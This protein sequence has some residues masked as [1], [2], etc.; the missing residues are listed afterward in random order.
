M[1]FVICRPFRFC[2]THANTFYGHCRCFTCPLSPSGTPD[3]CPGPVDS[4]EASDL[5]T[6]TANPLQFTFVTW[7]VRG[8]GDPRKQRHI[9]SYL[10]RHNVHCAMLQE[11]HLPPATRPTFANR[12]ATIREFSS[13]SSYA[14]GT[15]ILFNRRIPYTALGTYSDPQGRY[16]ILW[17]RLLAN[18]I[19]LVACYGPNT[20]DPE[21]FRVLWGKIAD[22]GSTHVLW[23]GDLNVTLDPQL[24]R[25][26]PQPHHYS[27]ARRELIDILAENDLVDAW[28]HTYP[29]GQ[30]GTCYS[31][32][33]SS[34]SR[35]DYWLMDKASASWLVRI[36]HL[37]RT[38]SDHSPVLLT[39]EPPATLPPFMHWRLNPTHLLDEAFKA[40]L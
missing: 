9:L 16:C 22:I 33:H 35:L 30:E 10:T 15:V 39:L 31:S 38:Y 17:G 2:I 13:Y 28:R 18:T 25:S 26:N 1:A 20:D 27:Q 12:W 11:T 3:I 34:W 29:T 21:F 19:T 4:D 5:M 8:L 6:D 36:K 23:G 7:N 37:P 14:R 32:A 40:D 24:Y